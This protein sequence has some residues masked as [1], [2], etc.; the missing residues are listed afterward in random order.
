M[1]GADDRHDSLVPFPRTPDEAASAVS[2]RPA[3]WIC[4]LFARAPLASD[5]A[6]TAFLLAEAGAVIATARKHRDHVEWRSSQHE[7]PPKAL[8]RLAHGFSRR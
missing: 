5:A 8:L 1:R 7:R 4:S 3:A 6:A 2:S